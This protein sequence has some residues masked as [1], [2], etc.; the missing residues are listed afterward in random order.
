[1]IAFCQLMRRFAAC[2]RYGPNR[3]VITFLLLVDR[4]PHKRDARAIRRN[5]WIA[6]PDKIEQIFFSDVALFG[7][8]GADPATNWSKQMTKCTN[9]E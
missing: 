5:L 2:E 6:D 9:D 1:M 8:S 7:E 3:S 4:H